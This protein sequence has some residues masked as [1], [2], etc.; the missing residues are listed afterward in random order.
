[1]SSCQLLPCLDD[2]FVPIQDRSIVLERNKCFPLK[3]VQK[4]FFKMLYVPASNFSVI[5]IV[6]LGLT[7]IEQEGYL[8]QNYN[9]VKTNQD[10]NSQPLAHESAEL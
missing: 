9:T 3:T 4:R 6:F 5:S 2:A 8:A 1:M 7:R 10:A